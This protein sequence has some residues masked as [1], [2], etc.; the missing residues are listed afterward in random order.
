MKMFDELADS[1]F[2]S[3]VIY[4]LSIVA[5]IIALKLLVSR[6]PEAGPVGAV[7]AGVLSV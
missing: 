7:R 3:W 1:G 5:F 6:L 2:G 4:G